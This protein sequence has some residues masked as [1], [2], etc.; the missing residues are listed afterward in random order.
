MSALAPST[1]R[2]TALDAKGARSSGTLE[3]SSKQAACAELERRALTPL[4]VQP[5][6]TRTRKGG[7]RVGQAQIARAY[8]QLAD[9]LRAGVPLLRALRVLGRSKSA[10]A[11][12]AVFEQVAQAVETGD[13][14]ADAMSQHPTVFKP[15]H[16]AMIRAGEKGGFLEPALVRL[17]SFVQGQVEL[18]NRVM[19]ALIYPCAIMGIGAI[20]LGVLFIV[21]VPKFA[22]KYSGVE[23]QLP[24]IIVMGVS[25]TLVERWPALLVAI[26]LLVVGS[27]WASRQEHLRAKFAELCSRLPIVGPLLRALAV[28]RFARILG[29]LIESGVPMLASLRIAKDAAGLPKMAQAIDDAADAVT[30]GDPLTAPLN[31]S[32][33]LGEDVVEMIGV[34]ESANNLGAVLPTIASTLEARVSRRL[35]IAVKLIEPI[36]ILMIGCVIAFVAL[37]LLLPMFKLASGQGIG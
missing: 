31:E 30:R 4:D 34:A 29:T 9:L 33:L 6:K 2:Y 14:L 20:I 24:T 12:A 28:A 15:I 32:G 25:A 37:G 27:V 21:F 7:P 35:D 1:F 22:D 16:I 17:S 13:D 10:P 23:L 19:G 26:G 8:T 5:T 11:S 18:R 36:T 3:A